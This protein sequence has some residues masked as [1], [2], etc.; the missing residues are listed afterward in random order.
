[1]E[2]EQLT[3]S[4]DLIRIFLVSDYSI[5]RDALRILL[6]TENHL[7]VIGEG[8]SLGEALNLS[9]GEKPDVILVD[10]PDSDH[11]QALSLL[12]TATDETPIIVLTGSNDSGIYQKCL[13]VSIRG[14]VPKQKSSSVL[15]KAIEKV[16]AGEYWIE[17]SIMGQTI[18]NLV[19]QRNF[20]ASD[21][22]QIEAKALSDREKQVVTLICRG[23]KNKDIAG[24]LFITETTVRH[25]LTSIFEKLGTKNRLELVVYAFKNSLE[26]LPTTSEVISRG[27]STTDALSVAAS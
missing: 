12:A 13:E 25:H 14:L 19:E 2:N 23:L 22:R 11:S 17:R 10:L 21:V 7:R 18:K 16:H 5:L 15:F 20:K 8:T 27:I 26:E 1:M 3:G 4:H 9:N 24:K 6:H